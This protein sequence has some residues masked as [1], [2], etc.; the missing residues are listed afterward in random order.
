MKKMYFKSTSCRNAC[1]VSTGV[2][3][4]SGNLPNRSLT[5]TCVM[6]HR[7]CSHKNINRFVT[8]SLTPMKQFCQFSP[9]LKNT[10]HKYLFVPINEIKEMKLQFFSWKISK[11]RMEISYSSVCVYLWRLKQSQ[12][13]EHSLHSLVI[14]REF[15]PWVLMKFFK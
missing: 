6:P 5:L 10:K 13:P 8:L 3:L 7:S 14:Q 1:P 2:Q 9:G 11:S 4:L 12:W 15:K